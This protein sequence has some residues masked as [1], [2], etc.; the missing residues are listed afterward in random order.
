M[1]APGS[2]PNAKKA[3]S[4]MCDRSVLLKRSMVLATATPK[5]AQARIARPHC[6]RRLNL[7]SHRDQADR[8]AQRRASGLLRKCG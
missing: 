6:V 8:P 3:R 5:T 2:T 4:S 7:V 1:N